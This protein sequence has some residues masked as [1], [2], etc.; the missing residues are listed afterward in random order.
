[1]SRLGTRPILRERNQQSQTFINSEVDFSFILQVELLTLG[2]LLK[3]FPVHLMCTMA[4]ET[5]IIV[6]AL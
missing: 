5:G 2:S 6:P 3:C 1:M 4:L